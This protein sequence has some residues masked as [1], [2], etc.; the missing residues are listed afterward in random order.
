MPKLGEIRRGV[1]FVKPRPPILKWVALLAAKALVRDRLGPLPTT[2]YVFEV[3]SVRCPECK[4]R[5]GLTVLRFPG[6]RVE[7][8]CRTKGC[9]SWTEQCSRSAATSR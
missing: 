8:T 6:G 7:A 1:P 3:A 2:L 5:A 9:L 4:R